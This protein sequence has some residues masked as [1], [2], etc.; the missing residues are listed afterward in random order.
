MPDNDP[1]LTPPP[2]APALAAPALPELPSAVAPAADT[3]PANDPGGIPAIALDPGAI[4][5]VNRAA[6]AAVSQHLG[7]GPGAKARKPRGKDRRPRQ[8]PPQCQPSSPGAVPL[9][10]MGNGADHTLGMEPAPVPL[11][12]VV[13]VVDEMDREFAEAGAA[14]C[15][16]TLND[17]AVM[18]IEWWAVYWLRDEQQAG[19]VAEKA[20]MKEE[21][22]KRLRR[23]IVDWALRNPDKARKLFGSML[24]IDPALWLADLGKL[25]TAIKRQGEQLRAAGRAP[26]TVPAQ[27]AA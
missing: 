15:T 13:P 9:A 20:R 25:A 1:Q 23:S 19:A 12:P 10:S 2:D 22:E 16:G 7:A 18:G 3:A 8:L 5:R 17:A 21:R 11:A 4:E 14:F 24:V 26:A 6:D 27:A